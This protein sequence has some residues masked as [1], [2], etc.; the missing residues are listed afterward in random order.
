MDENIVAVHMIETPDGT[1][2]V[3]TAEDI[4]HNDE[5]EIISA[6]DDINQLEQIDDNT[7]GQIIEG[8]EETEGMVDEE[9]EQDVK[10]HFDREEEEEEE[11]EE[12]DGNDQDGDGDGDD[13]DGDVE[14]ADADDI[15]IAE[16]VV[17]TQYSCKFCNRR[18]D[19]IDKV[20]NHYLLRHNKDQSLIQRF[21][22]GHQSATDDNE[23][24]ED[25]PPKKKSRP[26]PTNISKSKQN[27]MNLKVVSNIQTTVSNDLK[28]K[29]GRKPTGITRK[30][31]CDWPGCNYVARHSVIFTFPSNCDQNN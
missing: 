7:D 13:Q 12:N 15:I 30:Y 1:I 6:S 18:F 29:R 9:E 8:Q 28:K 14:S 4:Q 5:N 11:G 16:A 19:T 10:H 21:G 20:K 2:Q 31:P 24:A 23:D 26:M 17:V 3:L 25:L 27:Q 22:S